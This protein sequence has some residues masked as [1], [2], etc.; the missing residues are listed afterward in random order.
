[1][2]Y[3]RVNVN[4]TSFTPSPPGVP[5]TVE[6]TM[7]ITDQTPN[8]DGDPYFSIFEN[9]ITVSVP[10]GTPARL[11]YSLVNQTGSTDIFYIFGMFFSN[12][13]VRV[14]HN[15]GAFPLV[16]IGQDVPVQAS[17]EDLDI[18]PAQYT[19]SVV[20]QNGRDGF[21]AYTIGIQNL[22]TGVIGTFDPGIDNEQPP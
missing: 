3:C 20:D 1:M 6:A 19:V 22:N 17:M 12:A 14:E 5:S 16:L 10:Q 15:I 8:P 21:W 18:S 13:P 7:A 11:E 9:Q 2:I 4:M